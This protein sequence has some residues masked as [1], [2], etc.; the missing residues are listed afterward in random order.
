MRR[1]G[2][3][4]ALVAAAALLTASQHVAAFVP[5]LVRSSKLVGVNPRVSRSPP[6][7]PLCMAGAGGKA[8]KLESTSFDAGDADP[9]GSIEALNKVFVSRMIS[10]SNTFALQH[11]ARS[12][13]DVPS[14]AQVVPR[15]K[16]TELIKQTSDIEGFRQVF[17]TG[18]VLLYCYF[19]CSCQRS[20]FMFYV[21]IRCFMTEKT[22]HDKMSHIIS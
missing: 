15:P 7:Q 6:V 4:H 5:S 14:G 8:V 1:I 13:E 19:F 20:S 10:N 3:W 12:A 17:S 18:S 2:Q 21:T 22:S 9:V 11:Y 16:V